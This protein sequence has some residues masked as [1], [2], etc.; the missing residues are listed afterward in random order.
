M[1]QPLDLVEVDAVEDHFRRMQPAE[2]FLDRLVDQPVI[3]NGRFP[4]HAADQ[5]DGLQESSLRVVSSAA[6]NKPMLVIPA[7]AGIQFLILPLWIKDRTGSQPSL[8]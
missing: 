6:L 2:A 3:G 5:A 4:T 8:G 1:L 7:K